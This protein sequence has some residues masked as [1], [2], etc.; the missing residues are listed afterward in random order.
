M[1]RRATVHI[2]SIFAMSWRQI[3][4]R[5][6]IR[7]SPANHESMNTALLDVASRATLLTLKQIKFHSP[8][9]IYRRPAAS[10]RWY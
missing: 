8:P 3:E 7:C 1:I 6:A 9:S 5:E 2:A 4:T 10:C